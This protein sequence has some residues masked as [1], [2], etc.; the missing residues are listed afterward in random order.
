[1]TKFCARCGL[2]YDGK[3]PFIDNLCLKCYLEEHKLLSIKGEIVL[4]VCKSCGAVKSGSKWTSVSTNLLENIYAAL[5]SAIAQKSRVLLE[6]TKLH[7]HL[8]Q[9]LNY[10]FNVEVTVETNVKGYKVTQKYTVP[11]KIKL[12]LCPLCQKKLS[13]IHKAILQIRSTEQ[14]SPA[15]R[16]FIHKYLKELRKDYEKNIVEVKDL[17]EG[18]DIKLL[19]FTTARAIANKFKSDLG[20]L[21]KE[22]HKLIGRRN[23]KRESIMTISIRLPGIIPGDYIIYNNTVYLVKDISNGR[24]I[25]EKTVTNETLTLPISLIWKGKVKPI[26][27]NAVMDTL[28]YIT[29][30]DD[31]IYLVS[32]NNPQKTYIL[33]SSILPA[34]VKEGSEVKVVIINGK[35][36]VLEV[37]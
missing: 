17:K 22:T 26:P 10:T 13:G 30:E 5:P 15:L 8:P 11:A 19:S 18:I 24:L 9:T 23:G 31:L 28:I 34:S 4:E 14:F 7:I 16:K 3:I 25:V 21:V 36:Y 1:M 6:N 32:K 35:P 12:T 2:E 20:A 37:V 29:R 27:D 33:P